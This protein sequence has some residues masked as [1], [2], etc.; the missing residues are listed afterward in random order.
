[1]K[2]RWLGRIGVG[3][4]ALSLAV[5]GGCSSLTGS[6]ASEKITVVGKNFVEQDI[7]ANMVG[8]LLEKNTDLDVDIK[9]FLGGTDV[10][11]NAM[12]T[13]NADLYVEYTGTGLVN[14]LGMQADSDSE[15]VYDTVKAEFQKQYQMDWLEPIGFNNTYALAV[16]QETA[17]KYNLKTISDLKEHAGSLTLG[18]DQEF[19]E[20]DDGLKGLEK[21]YGLHF[22]NTKAMDS[23]LK[24]TAISAGEVDVVDAFTTDGQLI[25]HNLVILEDDQQF[26]PPYYAAPLVR[27]DVLQQHPEIKDVLNKLAGKIDDK[28]MAML[29]EKVDVEKQKADDVAEQWL[30]EQGLI[31]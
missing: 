28:Q 15:K 17:Q 3:A 10:C 31:K 30:K 18:S 29:N 2:M 21:T 8:I 23:G 20:R 7:M 19:I 26:F 11:F 4:L 22:T 13:G 12:K 27:S 6:K 1:M 25:K 16:T 14:I 5:L 9:P 24:Y